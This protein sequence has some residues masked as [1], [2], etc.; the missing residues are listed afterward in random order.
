MTGRQTNTQIQTVR[1]RYRTGTKTKKKEKN[2]CRSKEQ[3]SF[4]QQ[5]FIHL[6]PV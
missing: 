4:G 2:N 1:Q 6:F 3:D 5:I